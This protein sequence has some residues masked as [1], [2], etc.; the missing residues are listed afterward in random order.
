MYDIL[1]F[2]I[3]QSP[4]AILIID[5]NGGICYANSKFAR[6]N[7]LKS[8]EFV[9]KKFHTVFGMS[10]E[11]QNCILHTVSSGSEWTGEICRAAKSS[12]LCWE[13][14]HIS[15]VR[16]HGAEAITHFLITMHDITDRKYKEKQ[17]VH[18]ACRDPLTNLLNRNFF[19][20]EIQKSLARMGR[21]GNSGALLYMDIDNFKCINDTYGHRV[22]DEVIKSLAKILNQRVRETD[23]IGRMGGDEFTVLLINVGLANVRHVAAQII[24]TVEKYVVVT[25]DGQR[26]KF[27]VS[28][29]ISLFPDHSSAPEILLSYADIAMYRAKG[30]GRNRACVYEVTQEKPE[31]TQGLI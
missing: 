14:V 4:Y 29:G 25:E 28:I 2:A 6:L 3:E 17:L 20:K 5:V 22:G 30:E 19:Y 10:Q 7:G 24:E 12:K 13:H 18:M 8:N 27:T 15:P 26:V 23:I 21:Y 31:L 11:D 9:G 1:F 16:K